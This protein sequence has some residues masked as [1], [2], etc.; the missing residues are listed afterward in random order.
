MAACRAARHAL[1]AGLPL[2]HATTRHPSRVLTGAP[3]TTAGRL[4]RAPD[5]PT[6]VR[7]PRAEGGEEVRVGVGVRVRVGP[8]EFKL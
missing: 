3:R 1:R 6:S 5:T 2:H 8:V 7:G 4:P